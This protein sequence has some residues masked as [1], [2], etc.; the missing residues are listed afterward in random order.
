MKKPSIYLSRKS[1]EPYRALICSGDNC[2]LSL[3][4]AVLDFA[5]SINVFSPKT[6]QDSLMSI[7]D[8]KDKISKKFPNIKIDIS[9]TKCT[10]FD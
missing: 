5:Q 6:P 10:F 8:A 9:E 1:V 7:E 3:F 4:D 2:E